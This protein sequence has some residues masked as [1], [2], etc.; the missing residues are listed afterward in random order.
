MENRFTNPVERILD[1]CIFIKTNNMKNITFQL[2]MI[3]LTKLKQQNWFWSFVFISLTI[4][5][6][7]KN[8][9]SQIDSVKTKTINKVNFDPDP[10][11]LGGPV[12]IGDVIPFTLPETS[13]FGVQLKSGTIK[14]KENK[15]SLKSATVENLEWPSPGAVNINKTAQTTG[16]DG[17]WKINL[18]VEGKNIPTTTDVV[19]VIDDSG[20]MG[21]SKMNNAK[22]AANTFVD[23]LL[24][25]STG[26][27]VS[28]VT[29][30]G[31]GGTGQPQVDQGFTS[32]L[33]SLHN[34]INNISASGGTNLQGGF[35]AARLL[36]ESSSANKKVVILLSD[37]VPTYSYNSVYSTDF[38]VDCGT[39]SYFNI[40]RNDFES[41]HLFVTSSNYSNIVGSGSDFDYTA[42]TVTKRCS[43]K[44][45]TFNAGNH[46]IPT[47]YEAGLIMDSGADVYTIGFEVP[48]GGDEENVLIGSQNKG[49]YPANSG[50]ISSIY[51]AIRSNI[52]YAATNAVLTDPMSTFIVLESGATP[53]FS[54]LPNTSGDVVVSKGTVSFINNGYVLNDPDIPT[55]GNSNIIK[56]KI[57]WNIGT[58]SELGD[59]LYY[60]ITMAPN[61]DP[62]I[63]YDANEQTYMDYTDVYGTP[64]VQKTTPDNFTIPKVS[65]G[66]GSIEI[67]YYRVNEA[68]QPV[69]S[70][71]TV[72]P[73]NNAQK[74]IPGNSKYFEYNGSTALDVNQ[75]Y[76][77]N[78]DISYSSNSLL[79][80]LHCNFSNVSITPTTSEPNKKV[81]FGYVFSTPPLASNIEYCLDEIAS[82]LTA[83]LSGGHTSP[84]YKLFFY[85]SI[86]DDTP[87]N[88]ITP[89]TASIGSADYWVAEGISNSCISPARAKIT[90]TVK[91]CCSL[92]S[93]EATFDLIDCNGGNTDVSISAI[94]G[95]APLTYTL[96]G[97]SPQTTNT[98]YNIPAG[99]YSWSVSESGMGCTPKTGNITIAEPVV[100]SASAV[101]DS[102]VACNGESNGAATVSVSGGN[103]PYSYS[104]DKSA[105]ASASADDLAAGLHTITITDDK[106]DRKSVV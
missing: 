27:R 64:D 13:S 78:P 39:I 38:T 96:Q 69:N 91:N 88:S 100:L 1:V 17:R 15:I 24:T 59:N 63:L 41:D 20:S 16:T 85:T 50:N 83:T 14:S 89:S 48:V 51:S 94:G 18:L 7:A 3:N 71:G 49:Y 76:S 52:A 102:P 2:A 86:D 74:L 44:N 29:I 37:G 10:D 22:A 26:I 60:Y 56:W 68:G 33:T 99:T 47:K 28:V 95:L 58:V 19:L 23:E 45:R 31:G 5:L 84:D 42:Y 53:T 36:V 80:E 54:V 21:T 8:S 104:W 30:N 34:A 79:F 57:V 46:G 81:W 62:T 87:E 93:A 32:N 61:T 75:A 12:F 98:F 82:P 40:S 11:H 25:S 55:S 92:V 66:K 101:Q 106:G 90:V 35:Y 9:Y 43:G 97:F 6:I 105:S 65:G 67:I 4:S 77:I 72:V 103:A 70:V 73:L